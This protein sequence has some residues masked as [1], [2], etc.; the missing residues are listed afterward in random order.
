MKPAVPEVFA[1][2]GCGKEYPVGTKFCTECGGKVGK[3]SAVANS[4]SDMCDDSEQET[5]FD[6]FL[7][8]TENKVATIKEV[9]SITGAGLVAAKNMVETIPA[10]LKKNCTASEVQKIKTMLLAVGA[11]VDAKVHAKK[12]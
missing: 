1:C 5:L 11:K 10:C 8:S 3:K 7:V 9:R 4:D 2:I 6:I 12:K